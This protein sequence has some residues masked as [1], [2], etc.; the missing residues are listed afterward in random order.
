MANVTRRNVL[1]AGLSGPAFLAAL[2]SELI[3]S[4]SAQTQQPKRGGTLVY[5]QCSGNRRGGDA[6]NTRHPYFMVDLIT[7][8]AYNTL[9][10]VDE[11]LNVVNELATMV[12]PADDKLNVLGDHGP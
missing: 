5:A 1:L 8:S 3:G 11:G 7:R 10:W 6:S 9:T 4:A 2:D 12:A